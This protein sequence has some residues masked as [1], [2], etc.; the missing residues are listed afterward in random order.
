MTSV[1]KTV[2]LTLPGPAGEVHRVCIGDGKRRAGTC[3]SRQPD[4]GRAHR[5]W[6]RRGGDDSR[7]EGRRERGVGRPA[8]AHGDPSSDAGSVTPA[9]QVLL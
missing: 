3:H 9:A 2:C 1:D 4:G 6:P 8:G 7:V 5:L